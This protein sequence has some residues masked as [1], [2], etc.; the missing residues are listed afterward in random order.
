MAIVKSNNLTGKPLKT[1]L[2]TWPTL[3]LPL[4]KVFLKNISEIS[5]ETSNVELEETVYRI[6]YGSRRHIVLVSFNNDHLP[7]I[8]DTLKNF[9]TNAKRQYEFD[10]TK[11]YVILPP[12]K[13][14]CNNNCSIFLFDFCFFKNNTFFRMVERR[15]LAA[16]NNRNNNV[17][18]QEFITLC[19]RLN[20]S[21]PKKELEKDFRELDK[22]NNNVVD[23]EEFKYFSKMYLHKP[24]LLQLF[25]KV[26][27]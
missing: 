11:T 18:L 19:N 27:W 5:I 13:V 22:D 24:E 3:L 25:N 14:L 23:Y 1:K 8:V 9:I 21:K 10:S 12:S 15:W 26:P 6:T 20:I 2:L 17:D 7:E 16:D 4:H